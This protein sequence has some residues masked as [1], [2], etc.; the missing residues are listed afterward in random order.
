MYA[1]TYLGD[2][3]DM[4]FVSWAGA[5]A[6]LR[7][8][9]NCR[10]GRRAHAVST[11]GVD[12]SAGPLRASVSAEGR[13]VNA[14]D[15]VLADHDSDTVTVQCCFSEAVRQDEFWAG[16]AADDGRGL[17]HRRAHERRRRARSSCS[18]CTH[19]TH[20]HKYSIRHCDAV[21]NRIIHLC[22]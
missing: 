14:A 19:N 1:M 16:E 13:S 3:K 18:W 22:I 6:L 17:S 20:A 12:V 21:W 7:N 5:V 8:E 9:G 4:F 11:M 15:A 10:E 2:Q